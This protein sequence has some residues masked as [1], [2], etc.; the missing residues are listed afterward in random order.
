MVRPK[1]NKQAEATS[2]GGSGGQASRLG[3]LVL[4]RFACAQRA[5]GNVQAANVPRA[6]TLARVRAAR[7]SHQ[8]QNRVW[9]D[10]TLHIDLARK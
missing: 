6:A 2:L 8:Q 1:G 3:H 5:N 4:V 7:L 10:A 9:G